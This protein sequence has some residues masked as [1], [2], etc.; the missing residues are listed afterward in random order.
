MAKTTIPD[1]LTRRHWLSEEMDAARA[2]AAANAYL[3]EDR[4]F[5]AIAFFAKAGDRDALESLAE[6]GLTSG[7][8]F[9]FRAAHEALKVA[10]TREMWEKLA[11]TAEAAGK[12]QYAIEARRQVAAAGGS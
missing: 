6:E 9:L 3:A 4:R 11:S 12:L 10:P 8:L 7:D 1:A 2:S 5:E